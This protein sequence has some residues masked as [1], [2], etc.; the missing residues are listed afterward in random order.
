MVIEILVSESGSVQVLGRVI[1]K[2]LGPT[3]E[4]FGSENPL[5]Q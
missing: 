4:L 2:S 3:P 5:G 1:E